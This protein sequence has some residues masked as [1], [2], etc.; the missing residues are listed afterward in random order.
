MSYCLYL[1]KSRTDIEAE[2][3]GEGETLARHEKSLMNLAECLKLNI[4]EI[5]REIVSGETIAARPIMQKLLSEVEQSVWDGVLVMEVERLARGDTIDQ[6]IVAQTFKYSN[7]KI[8][9][10]MKIYDPNNEY[11]EEYFEFGLFMSRREYKTINRRLQRG[12][13]QSVKEGKYLGNKP[14]YGYV[15]KKLEDQKGYTLEINPKQA[16]IVK[17]IFELYTRGEKQ[18]N[19]EYKRLG[20]GLIVRKLNDLRIPPMKGDVWVNSSILGILRNPTYTGKIRWNS[21]PQKKKMV[22]GQMKKERPRANPKDWIL[23]EG[24]HE[25]IINNYTFNLAQEYLKTNPSTPCPKDRGLKNPLSG[26]I[27]C[28]LCGRKMVRRSYSKKEYPDT[29]ICPSTAC[30]NI[31]S[32]LPYIEERLLE[33]LEN[34]LRGYKITWEAKDN[35]KSNQDIQ[36]D[37]KRKALKT[38]DKELKNLEKQMENIHDLLEQGVYSVDTFLERSK[39]LNDEIDKTQKD[40]E[41]LLDDLCFNKDKDKN[42]SQKIIIPKVKK[43]LELYKVT[44]DPSLKNELLKEVVSKAVYT[45][46]TKNSRWHDKS[47]DFDLVLSPKLSFDNNNL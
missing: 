3:R 1:R 14:P 41:T 26:L 8:I 2:Y 42:E 47:D 45:K 35:E 10:P 43:L 30:P 7:T 37:I 6:G 39:I 44:D 22:D 18:E 15:R 23:V 19:R 12:R 31:S 24:L 5:Y 27:V 13:I 4:T 21:R 25:A 46:T 11:D 9:T 28:G 40:R 29:L 33:A 36:I 20:V 17:M 34:W 38:L 32:Q 16:D